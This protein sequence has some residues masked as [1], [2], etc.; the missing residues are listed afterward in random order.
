MSVQH[1]DITLSSADKLRHEIVDAMSRLPDE[2]LLPMKELVDSALDTAESDRVDEVTLRRIVQRM[3]VRS[4]NEFFTAEHVSM[5][6]TNERLD[7]F[8]A[9][10][11]PRRIELPLDVAMVETPIDIVMSERRSARDYL[12][13]PLPLE[14]F[15]GVLKRAFGKNGSEDGYGVRDLPLFPYPSMGGLSAFDIGVVVQ[16]VEGISRGYYRYDQVGHSLVPR[17]SGDMRLALQ[18]ATFE[19]DWLLYAPFVVVMVH[20]A[21][22]FQ[23]KYHTRGYRIAHIDMGAAVES[24]YL[25]A[26]SAGLSCCAV[27]GFLDEPINDLL[28]YDGYDKYVSLVLGVGRPAT[29]LLARTPR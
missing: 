25:A 27:A 24:L 21:A 3:F 17:I 23:W 29:P 16:N 1:V 10:Q 11:D 15:S 20:D 9:S 5:Q 2:A 14:E 18:D 4:V 12:A 28:G 8:R 13:T 19:S 22:A 6:M 7:R 26:F